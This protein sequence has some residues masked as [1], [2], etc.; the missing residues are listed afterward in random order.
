MKIKFEVEQD[1]RG[2]E[3]PKFAARTLKK[4]RDAEHSTQVMYVVHDGEDIDDGE[5]YF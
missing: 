4:D 5:L 1:R 2:I 3:N